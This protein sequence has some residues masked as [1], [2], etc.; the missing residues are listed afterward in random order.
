MAPIRIVQ[1][2]TP[3][4]QRRV[5]MV[6]GDGNHLHP[7]ADTASV[8]ELAEDAIAGGVTIASLVEARAE[9]GLVDYGALLAEGRVLAKNT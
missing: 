5:G 9:P 2:V 7:L 8:R 1:Y 6:A 4:G 3:E